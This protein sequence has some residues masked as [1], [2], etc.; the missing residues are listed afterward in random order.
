[1]SSSDPVA[2]VLADWFERR[3]KGAAET[4]EELLAAHPD[5]ADELRKRVDAAGVLD[6]VFEEEDDEASGVPETIGDFRILREIGRGG[7]GAVYEARQE[8]IGRLVALKVLSPSITS[9]REAVARFRREAKAA[10]RLHHTN[11]VPIYAMGRHGGHWYYAMELVQGRALSQIVA[12]M[13]AEAE[14]AGSRRRGTPSSG[15]DGDSPGLGS[16]TGPRGYWADL[17]D[18]FAAVAEALETAHVQGVIHRDIKPANIMLDHDGSLKVVDFG[19]ARLE[20]GDGPSLTITGRIMGTPFYMSPEQAMARRMPVDH[21]T[22]IYSLGATMYEILTQSPP[23]E[24]KSLQE[25]CSQIIT[26]EPVLPRRVDGRIPRDLE[27]VVLKA[28]EKDP[29]KRYQT[30]A[31]FARDLRRFA[32]GGAI[33]AR[34]IGIAG[35]SWRRVKRNKVRSALVAAVLILAAAGTWFALRATE[36]ARE[37][38]QLEYARLCALGEEGVA[39][40]VDRDPGDLSHEEDEATES[41]GP[42]LAFAKAIEIEPD[43]FEAYFGRALVPGRSEDEALDDLASAR[44]RG[45]GERTFRLARAY[46][47]TRHGRWEEAEIEARRAEGS[48]DDSLLGALLES[49]LLEVQGRTEEA[50]DVLDR[51]LPDDEGSRA[52]RYLSL[53]RRSR[54]RMRLGD[55]DGALAD[56]AA[57]REM[58]DDS[59]RL[60]VRMAIAWSRLGKADIAE[61]IYEECLDRARREGTEEI[62][63]RLAFHTRVHGRR[64]WFDRSTEEGLAAHP[65]SARLLQERVFFLNEAKRFE[66]ALDQVERLRS[67]VGEA[68]HT[69]EKMRA[70]TLLGI[71][72]P[73]EA[74]VACRRAVELKDD[75]FL[76]RNQMALILLRLGRAEEALEA[77]E[78]VSALKPGV[79]TPV[80]NRGI[81][82]RKLGRLDEAIEAFERSARMDPSQAGALLNHGALLSDDLGKPAEALALFDRARELEPGESKIHFNRG[83]V[84]TKLGRLD[85]ATEAYATAV[86]LAPRSVG[87]HQNYWDLLQRLD[88]RDEMRASMESTLERDPDSPDALH[89]RF[90]ALHR[91]GRHEEALRAVETLLAE[92]PASRHLLIDRAL[93]LEDLGR[94]EDAL[95]TYDEILESHPDDEASW[96]NRGGVLARLGRVEEALTSHE[97][98][99]ALEPEDDTAHYNRG[100]RL[101]HLGRLDEALASFSRHVEIRPRDPM[102]HVWRGKVHRRRNHIDEAMAAFAKAVEIGPRDFQALVHHASLLLATGHPAEALALYDR[103]ALLR[104]DFFAVHIDR[105]RA[106]AT[107][108]SME[109]ALESYTRAAELAPDRAGPRYFVALALR[110]LGR[111]EEALKAFDEAA[112]R[113][114][115]HI[116]THFYKGA[117]LDLLGRRKEALASLDRVLEIDPRNGMAHSSR[118]HVLL[119]LERYEEAV[120]A[121]RK[122]VEHA[123]GY[124][125]GYVHF[126]DALREAGDHEKAILVLERAAELDPG[127]AQPH[128]SIAYVY[129]EQ[130]RHEQALAAYDAALER[131]PESADLHNDRGI[132]L[133][134]LERLDEA[135]EAWRRALEINPRL[136][137][138]ARNLAQVYSHL[139]RYPEALEA[140][141]RLLRI[142]PE[143]P[144]GLESRAEALWHLGR[145]EQALDAFRKVL[146][147]VPGREEVCGSIVRILVELGQFP[148][149]LR[150]CE[151]YLRMDQSD[152]NRWWLRRFRVVI[153][154]GMGR[155]EDAAAVAAG[156]AA[157]ECPDNLELNLAYCLAAAGKP[158]RAREV[159]ARKDYSRFGYLVAQIHAVI[160]DRDAAVRA[161]AKAVD[162]GIFLPPNSALEPDFR[163]LEEDAEFRALLARARKVR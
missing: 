3:E 141:N 63:K 102:G 55:L 112:E 27:T 109:G 57:Q 128:W 105:G 130:G 104:P 18:R 153:L 120:E 24:G 144:E 59:L 25:V 78:R 88:R 77:L 42:L 87:T 107:A 146:A 49:Q 126:G 114:P 134:Q 4:L 123:P 122:A 11:I 148:R 17:A 91:L 127:W 93:V 97:K 80:T 16:S 73:E 48:T 21:R 6:R 44:D 35:R 56:L 135:F 92:K 151:E 160:G 137:H 111:H 84:L 139:E 33:R 136:S 154:R 34:R 37:K 52:I 28:M 101:W 32:E 90:H 159:L 79:A 162:G 64:T 143:D 117:L 96:D 1:V 121:G 131:D 15:L 155:K 118:C 119:V 103:A 65:D 7:M 157:E 68:T 158:E 98:A 62:W 60:R 75:C 81:A 99:I 66:E 147:K 149:A 85:E 58:G 40:F 116:G 113:D 72:R 163:E 132:A 53:R 138:S 10:G 82:L 67:T 70:I 46:V 9:S 95:A 51:A 22:D 23:F 100:L 14:R 133:R 76:A 12:E 106:R 47:L 125:W 2:D 129:S 71:G 50:A 26:K 86:D 69:V 83:I 115:N 156:Y 145:H 30:A 43:R 45:L 54:L 94:L 20:G 8:S 161:F 38:S 31:S 41:A 19:L 108:G 150:V 140:W 61:R 74:L 39:R 89:V 124:K 152:E 5:M 29:D 142:V 13:K 36:A 110:D